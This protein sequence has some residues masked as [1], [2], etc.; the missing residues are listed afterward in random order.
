[1]NRKVKLAWFIALI[2]VGL[3]AVTTISPVRAFMASVLD[4][5]AG[6]SFTITDD[7][8]GD[9]DPEPP[10]IIHAQI[11]PL[12]E[13]I[14]SFPHVIKL[15]TNIPD[16]FVLDEDSVS[17]YTGEE[18][19]PF[20]DTIT[21]QWESDGAG[22]SG[23]KG[24]LTLDVT[25]RTESGEIIGPDS[26]EEVLLRDEYPAAFIEGGWN[27]NKK[28]WDDAFGAIRLRWQMDGLVYSVSG[29]STAVTVEQL[30]EIASSTLD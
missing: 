17:I 3:L 26:I 30:I 13:A 24:I 10:T 20:A 7:Y 28:K 27:Y 5:I 2:T 12:A 14:D 8:P 1:M 29:Q 11:M 21:I 19:A 9:D 23:E 16:G 22:E 18:A 25:N 4:T 15:P 6:Q